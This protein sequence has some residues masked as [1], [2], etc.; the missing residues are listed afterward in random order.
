MV[1]EDD[2]LMQLEGRR[3]QIKWRLLAS[4]SSPE[5]TSCTIT[6]T[7]NRM[8]TTGGFYLVGD[9]H[10]KLSQVGPTVVPSK[11]AEEEMIERPENAVVGAG[12]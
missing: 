8:F 3:G 10:I 6:Q 12:C 9:R 4:K 5:E 1:S 7:I 2:I 11:S